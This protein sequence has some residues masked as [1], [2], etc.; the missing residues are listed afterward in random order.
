M[1]GT[2]ED[3]SPLFVDVGVTDIK[4]DAIYMIC[5]GLLVRLLV[6]VILQAINK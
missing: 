4:I 3:G 6:F 5:Y 2:F 1:K